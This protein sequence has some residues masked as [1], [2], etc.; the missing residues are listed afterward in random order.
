MGWEE[1]KK[2]DLGPPQ[3]HLSREIPYG[4]EGRKAA[5]RQQPWVLSFGRLGK[6]FPQVLGFQGLTRGVEREGGTSITL[7]V[8]SSYFLHCEG[9]F[10]SHFLNVK[11]VRCLSL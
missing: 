9:F 11:A 10:I 4:T 6:G 8:E 3:S 2:G 5:R 1:K 7:K